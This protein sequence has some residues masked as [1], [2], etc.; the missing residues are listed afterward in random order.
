MSAN[1]GLPP[2][3]AGL[4]NANS[5][6]AKIPVEDLIPYEEQWVAWN[7]DS[8]RILAWGKE[9]EDLERELE[10]QGIDASQVIFEYI[11]SLP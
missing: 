1:N 6:R 9:W 3:P 10:R 4:G 5:E 2:L 11:S 8:T 7:G